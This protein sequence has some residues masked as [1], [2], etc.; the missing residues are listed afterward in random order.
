MRLP[1]THQSHSRNLF[2]RYT[3]KILKR[4]MHTTIYQNIIRNGW[5]QETTCTSLSRRLAEQTVVH[6]YKAALNHYEEAWGGSL[7]T[8]L[9]RPQNTFNKWERQD[10]E[11]VYYATVYRRENGYSTYT[12]YGYF[13][14]NGG[15]NHK[16][17][18]MAIYRGVEGDQHRR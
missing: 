10:R 3:S 1:L 8:A 16:S 9:E 18:K 5:R 14:N 15:I 6:P 4:R 17:F 2:P 12:H 11:S 7:T 13:F